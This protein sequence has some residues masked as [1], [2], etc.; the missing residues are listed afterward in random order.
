MDNSL[1]RKRVT[2]YELRNTM[3][4]QLYISVQADLQKV[5]DAIKSQLHSSQPVIN[6]IA[7]YVIDN[8]GK[9]IRPALFLL[10]AKMAG[11]SGDHLPK[12][13]ASFEMIHTAS[14]LHDDVVDDANLRRGRP[15]SKAKW[16]NQIS[17][18]VGDFLWCKGCG[19]LVDHGSIKLLD[20][21]TKSIVSVTEG[22]LLEISRQNDVEMDEQGYF[23]IIRGKTAA[24]FAACCESAGHAAEVSEQFV[25]ALK[26]YGM[27]LGMAFQL[28]DDA[29][30]Y[31][32]DEKRFGKK[33]GGDL[34]EGRLTYPL[35]IA[36]KQAN[37]DE[38]RAI[39]DALIADHLS[40]EQFQAVLAI[41]QKYKGVDATI[42]LAHEYA[43]KAI[44]SLSIFKPSMERDALT[45]AVNYTVERTV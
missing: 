24:L 4:K 14:L 31:V 18:L 20:V 41:I 6:E 17:V 29:L 2:S 13:A 26:R 33:A 44:E 21:V 12:V 7:N 35:I 19:L 23:D 40:D 3:L 30:D 28:S 43:D 22:V 11:A 36:L 42:Q 16:G 39:R 32:S 1:T 8:G 10:S 15:S 9:R 5:E 38:K 37:E 34:R 25:I 27:D 45:A